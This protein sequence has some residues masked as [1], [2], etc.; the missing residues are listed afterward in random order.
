[1][2]IDAS[3]SSPDVLLEPVL[4]RLRALGVVNEPVR[5]RP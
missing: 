4:A 5:A 2:T 1:V 3:G